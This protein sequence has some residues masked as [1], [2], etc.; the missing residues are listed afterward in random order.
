MGIKAIAVVLVSAVVLPLHAARA[1]EI[2]STLSF[3]AYVVASGSIDVKTSS[4]ASAGNS[5]QTRHVAGETVVTPP[6]AGEPVSNCTS[7]TLVCTGPTSMRIAVRTDAEDDANSAPSGEDACAS[8]LRASGNGLL[9]CSA[10]GA[11]APNILGVV[12]D[13]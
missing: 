1:A 7:V 12:I 13:Y 11:S 5:S 8:P 2:R 6:A 10:A 4:P 3:S 9:L